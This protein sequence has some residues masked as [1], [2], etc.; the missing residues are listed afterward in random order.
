MKVDV[1]ATTALNADVLEA[2][3]G[4]N[5]YEG[6]TRKNVSPADALAE[7]AGRICYLSFSRPNPDTATNAGYL[8]NILTQAHYSV[9]EHASATFLVRGV[10]RALLT[11]LERHRHISFSVVSQRYVNYADTTPVVPPAFK[12]VD[13]M[14]EHLGR[15]Y[16]RCVSA[17]EGY[18]STLIDRGF[19]RK[20]AREAARAILPNAAPVDMVVT[21][22]LRA[23]RDV[24]GKRYHPAADAEI[25]EFAGLV[26][27]HLRDIA[28]NSFQ[29]L[30]KPGGSA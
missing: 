12:S 13:G 20:Q 4:Y 22:N 29:D 27:D 15:E 5:A 6:G 19:K 23:W 21:G 30:Q 25:F 26:L 14:P 16:E 2:A 11:E 8:N 18:V 28:P 3:Y 10:S 17:Y 24:L 7:G 9:L 1:L